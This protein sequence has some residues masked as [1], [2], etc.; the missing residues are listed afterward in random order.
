MACHYISQLF[1]I[2]SIFRIHDYYQEALSETRTVILMQCFSTRIKQHLFLQ[3]KYSYRKV[4]M[5]LL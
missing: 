4:S 5:M 3:H 1:I 2:L